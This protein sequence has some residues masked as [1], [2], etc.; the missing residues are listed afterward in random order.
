VKRRSHTPEQIIRKLRAADRLL[1]EGQ[2]LAAV[3]KQ[4]EVSEATFHRWRAQ[5]GGMTADDAK[6]LREPERENVRLKAIVADQALENRALRVVSRETGEPSPTASGGRDAARS[7][8]CQRAEGVPGGWGSIAPP[9][10][11][12]RPRR[13]RIRR[14]APG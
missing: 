6:R 7:S 4:L 8:W 13:P 1:G 14:S 11:T 12:S 3:A 9:D 5:Y 2:D 10:A